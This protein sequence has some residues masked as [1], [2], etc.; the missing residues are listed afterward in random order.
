MQISNYEPPWSAS[1]TPIESK[2]ESSMQRTIWKMSALAALCAAMT[3][4]AAVACAAEEPEQPV[5]A[6]QPMP[7]A[8]AV[9]PDYSTDTMT[10]EQA[11]QAQQQPAPAAPARA[12]ELPAAPQAA[13]G[14][15]T[16]SLA[17]REGQDTTGDMMQMEYMAPT[18]EPGGYPS[19]QWDGPVPTNL[20]ESPQSAD[21]VRKGEIL[22]LE[23][24]LPVREDIWVI[25]PYDEIGVYGGTMRITTH[26]IKTLD[27]L[28]VTSLVN[29]DPV[30]TSEP[31]LIKGWEVSEDGRMY[32]FTNRR[33]ARWSDGYPMTIEDVRFAMED[34]MYN[35][36]L[37]PSLPAELKSQITGNPARFDVVDDVTWTIQFDDPYFDLASSRHMWGSS[38]T[39]GCPRCYYAPSH[40]YKRYHSKYNPGE[41]DALMEQYGQET[42]RGLQN[43]IDNIRTGP[44]NDW[45]QTGPIPTEFDPDFIYMGDIYTPAMSE[46]IQT[47]CCEGGRAAVRNHYFIGVDPE[48]N[49]LPY[50][51]EQILILT[52]DRTVAAFRG[53]NG[54]N[55]Y[56][57]GSMILSELPLY[58]ANME[59]GDYS[60]YIFRSPA[61]NDSATAVQQ[62]F[63]QDPEMGQLLRTKDFRKALSIATDRNEMNEIVASGIG[64]PQQWIP[65]PITPY[66]PGKQYADLDA[67]YDLEGAKALMTKMGYTDA[68]GD[69]FLDRKDESGPLSLHY[70][71][72][73]LYVPHL[74]VLQSHWGDLGI[75]VTIEEGNSSAVRQADPKLPFEH[76]ISL[77]SMNQWTVQWTRAFS[78]TSGS[79]LGAAM[80]D[81]WASFGQSGMPP[82][83]GSPMYQDA[84]GNMA[85]DGTY[86]ADITG[87]IQRMQDIW[88]QGIQTGPVLHPE[89]VEM[90]KE[91]WRISAEEKYNIGYLAFMGI[92]RGM[93]MKRNNLR[94]VPKNHVALEAKGIL[95]AYYFEDGLDNINNQGNRSRKY[96]SVHFLDP[97]YWTQ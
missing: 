60:V 70:V 45:R 81:Y 46:L 34:L 75:M 3:A 29:G 96:K 83:G 8:P 18:I 26:H 61:G 42:V 4:V 49:Q 12:A 33:G 6:A 76:H 97:E 63:V 68:D 36:E 78:G 5:P 47:R 90:G 39:R 84:Y 19:H 91:F 62:E 59:Q 66:F 50:M 40:I 69:G 30:G 65:H 53:M 95:G 48:G 14:G 38:K 67:G 25:A 51:D 58:M 28:A 16:R 71:A 15:G 35:T 20:N 54:E 11:P 73:S 94:N 82:T 44:G 93:T 23:E 17:Q 7:A 57:G 37:N 52:E 2:E 41:I 56:Y 74:E 24:R 43:S 85:P 10:P 86:P 22:P 13:A 88:R 79:P 72:S 77:Y 55:D 87:N 80:G 92:V 64:T 1:S 32:T 21:L 89:R 31:R 9:A 27:H